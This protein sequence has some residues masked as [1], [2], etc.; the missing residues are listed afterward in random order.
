MICLLQYNSYAENFAL[1][2]LLI[3]VSHRCQVTCPNSFKKLRDNESS[4][5][6]PLSEAIVPGKKLYWDQS[7][8]WYLVLFAFICTSICLC[9][10]FILFDHLNELLLYPNIL[11][12]VVDGV[13]NR[14]LTWDALK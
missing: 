8:A 2:Q 6:G 13:M 12:Y 4:P 11:L 14:I 9:S 7:L 1:A 10:S 3:P 5:V